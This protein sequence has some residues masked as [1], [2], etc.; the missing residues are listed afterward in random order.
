VTTIATD[1]KS[2]AADR[3]VT[4]NGLLHGEMCKIAR[5]TDGSIAAVT[6]TPYLLEAFVR[7]Y[8]SGTTDPFDP[9]DDGCEFLVLRPDGSVR[10][11][12]K[13]GRW[14]ECGAPAAAGSGSAV[15]YG[16][17]DAG[18]TAEQAV[19]IAARRDICSGC[20]VDCM[21]L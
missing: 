18:A 16:A 21:S 12:D 14:Y 20:G 8:D 13:F 10:S 15:A 4:G 1:G 19:R 9:R 5:A 17:L 7:W 3:A 6:G 11:Y 2:M